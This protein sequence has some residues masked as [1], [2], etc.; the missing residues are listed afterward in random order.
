MVVQTPETK[1]RGFGY[2]EFQLTMMNIAKNEV[3]I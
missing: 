2:S 1:L 3:T